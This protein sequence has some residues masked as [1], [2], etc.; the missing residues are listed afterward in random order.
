V[1][2]YTYRYYDPL[3]GRWPSRDPIGEEGGI[4]L[5]GFVGNNSVNKLDYLGLKRLKLK[6]SILLEGEDDLA[7][8][9]MLNWDANGITTSTT[10]VA[11]FIEKQ[12]GKY[13]EDGIGDCN[14]V[15]NLTIWTHGGPGMNNNG[16]LLGHDTQKEIDN[17]TYSIERWYNNPNPKNYDGYKKNF[18]RRTML[19]ME[20]DA[21]DKIS[22][23]MCKG[24]KLNIYGCCVGGDSK[25]PDSLKEGKKFKNWLEGVFPNSEIGKLP[26][27]DVTPS[28]YSDN[29]KPWIK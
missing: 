21:L 22:S 19:Q 3:T 23:L 29:P 2:F 24:S 25:D 17:L 1:T 15:D 4:N 18:Y 10:M 14:C 12:V 26:T 20:L 11:Y 16:Y 6:Y 28:V 13:H 27:I 7:K 5:Y 9:K 8:E